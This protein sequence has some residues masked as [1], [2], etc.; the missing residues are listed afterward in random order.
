M[1][2][3]VILGAGMM[4]SAFSIPLAENGHE[5]HLVGTHLDGDIIEEVHENHAHPRLKSRLVET[6]RPY[7]WDRLAEAMVDAELV[8]LG[9][10][11][12]GIEWA[13]DMLGPL[14]SPDIPVLGLTKG[15]AGNGQQLSTLPDVFRAD[16]PAAYRQQVKINAIGG[17][18]IAGELAARRHTC[19]VITG[20]DQAYLTGWLAGCER[21]ITMS[22]PIPIWSVWNSAWP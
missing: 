3:I 6:V 10:N 7:T 16:L 22:G 14:L 19:V 2:K 13:A 12:L 8:V 15:L 17:P 1:A 5:V 9:V 21:P 4:G 20:P 18:S 11:S